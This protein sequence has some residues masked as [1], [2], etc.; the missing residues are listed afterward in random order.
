[1]CHQSVGLIARHLEA[2]GVPTIGFTSA[3]SITV[4]ANPP[5]SVFVD[6]PLG[7][8]TGLPNDVDGQRTLL[9]EG[10]SAASALTGPGV[11]DLPYRYVDDEWKAAPLG[12]SRKRQ[13]SGRAS[14]PSGDSRTGRSAEPQYQSDDDRQAA[15]AVDWDDQ[16]LVCVGLDGP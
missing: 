10:L 2:A 5:R 14:K 15:E 6:L 13:S 16:C 7:H 1:M 9:T 3:R 4:S 11:V 8:T 12:W